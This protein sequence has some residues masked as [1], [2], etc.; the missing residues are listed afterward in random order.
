MSSEK[1]FASGSQKRKQKAKLE[2]Q[3][4]KIPKITAF[5]PDQLSSDLAGTS[6]S[7]EAPGN[8]VDVDS[9]LEVTAD[10]ADAESDITSNDAVAASTVFSTADDHDQT[11][12][13]SISVPSTDP[14]LWNTTDAKLID[15]WILVDLKL[16]GIVTANIVNLQGRSRT[17]TGS[18]MILH[19][20]KLFHQVRR[21]RGIGCC[22]HHR[23]VVFSVSYADYSNP[24]VNPLCVKMD[25]MLGITSTDSL[26][27]NSLPIIGKPWNSIPFEL[28]R[29]KHWIV[30]LQTKL[31]N[32]KII[33]EKF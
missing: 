8:S 11:M 32:R 3:I 26:T 7:A 16:A 1:R 13:T 28:R 25:S 27:M 9:S 17:L 20:R 10:E 2:T 14:A 30:F 33:G 5:F 22:I 24:I 4:K 19:S 15:Y 31:K 29:K 21:S 6:A 23:V 18:S 12:Q